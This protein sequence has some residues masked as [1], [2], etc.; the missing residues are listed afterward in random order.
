MGDGTVAGVRIVADGEFGEC[1][2][3]HLRALLASGAAPA[4]GRIRVRASWRDVPAEFAA[5]GAAT[6]SA[7]WL[8]IALGHPYI[9]V[10]PLFVTGRA[11]CPACYATRVRQHG[12]PVD[13]EVGRRLADDP[14]LGVRGFLPHQ[15]MIAAGLAVDLMRDEEAGRVAVVDCRTDEVASWH[16]VPAEAC[17]GCGPGARR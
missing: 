9:R 1:V 6:G 17:P 15:S 2:A 14:R 11:P 3:G 13:E 12:N 10:G 5:F 8:P 4:S 16:L 7:P